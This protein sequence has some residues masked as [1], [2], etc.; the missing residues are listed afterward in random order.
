V[1]LAVL[2]VVF[3]LLWFLVWTKKALLGW[4]TLSRRGAFLVGYLLFEAVLVAMTELSSIGHHFTRQFV[5]G[6]WLFVALCLL[7][8]SWRALGAYLTAASRSR[9]AIQPVRWVSQALRTE[10]T[11]WLLIPAFYFGVFVYLALA[12]LPSNGDSLDYHLARVEHWIQDQSVGPFPAHFTAQVDYSPLTEYNLAHFHL[13]FGSD[14]LD[15]FVQLFAAIVCVVAVSEIARVLGATRLVQVGAVVV[16]TT[17]PS[18]ALSATSTENNI[19]AASLGACLIFVLLAQDPIRHWRSFALFAGLAAGLAALTKGTTVALVG[20]AAVALLIWRIATETEFA[21]SIRLRRAA[22]IAAGIALTA[23]VIAGPFLYQDQ[24]IFGSPDGP[25]AQ[26]VLSTNLTWRAAGADI[27]RSTAANFMMGNGR[28]GPETAVSKFILGKFHRVY[29]VFGISQD[30]WDYFVGP[31][32]SAYFD[33]F[34]VRDYT[35]WD[36][37]EDEGADPLD[38]VLICLTGLTCVVLLVRGDRRMRVLVLMAGSLTIGYLVF[39]GIA[40]FQIFEV[41]FYIPLF[42]I[43]SPLIAIALARY[44]KWLLRIAMVVLAVACLPQLL[45]NSERPVLRNSYGSHPL[46]PYFLDSTDRSYIIRTAV[47]METLS[48]VIAESTCKQLGI[49][50][51]VVIEYPVWVGLHNDHWHG[52]IQDV[53]VQNVT[54][55]FENPNFHPCAILTQPSAPYVGS[56][57]G[58]VQIGFGPQFALSILPRDMR[59]VDVAIGGFSSELAGVRV[60]PG[61]GWSFAA[62]PSLSGDGSVFLYSQKPQTLGLRLQGAHGSA[63]SGVVVSTPRPEQAPAVSDTNGLVRLNVG[64]GITEVDLA[65]GHGRSVTNPV[66]AVRVVAAGPPVAATGATSGG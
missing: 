57:P 66:R 27:V 33:A 34:A 13:L 46:A 60:F 22:Q 64:A 49:G 41:R 50:N 7:G 4:P 18:F 37:S 43:W 31:D 19:F 23:L 21:P 14:R 25:D 53:K 38:V 48:K 17:I 35:A 3:A 36:R 52:Q 65:P 10:E 32:T 9:G 61:S 2:L 11:F 58:R 1:A 16:C 26:A 15:G 44:S 54:A 62:S 63:A 59:T 47:D 51:F 5:L 20:P 24:S 29:D 8:L 12:Y 6:G 30:N 39:A 56:E 28:S 40:R 42:V 45:D 55:R